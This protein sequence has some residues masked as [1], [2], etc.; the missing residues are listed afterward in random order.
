MLLATTSDQKHDVG[1]SQMKNI[2]KQQNYNY[3]KHA[4][5]KVNPAKDK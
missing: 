2:Y 1:I 4:A 5:T 3:T